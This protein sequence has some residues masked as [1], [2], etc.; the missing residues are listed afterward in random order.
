MERMFHYI[1]QGKEIWNYMYL[2]VA[3]HKNELLYKVA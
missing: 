1:T 3:I 2:D